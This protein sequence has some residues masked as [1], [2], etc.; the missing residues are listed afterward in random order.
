MSLFKLTTDDI[1]TTTIEMSSQKSVQLINMCAM[2]L[3]DVKAWKHEL[4]VDEHTLSNAINDI[5][6]IK[7]SITLIMKGEALVTREQSHIDEIT[8][9]LIIDVPNTY[10]IIPTNEIEL[11][12]IL[13]QLVKNDYKLKKS[14][15]YTFDDSTLKTLTDYIA[16]TFIKYSDGSGNADFTIFKNLI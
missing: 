3:P 4:F 15:E 7:L 11:Q 8:N 16:N 2:N 9:E 1:I 12:D 6:E 10:N 5:I 13:F 14:G